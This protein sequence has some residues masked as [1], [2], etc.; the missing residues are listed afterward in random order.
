MRF[1]VL[2]E[3]G[4]KISSL[5]DLRTGHEWMWQN[6]NLPHRIPEYGRNFE[7][8]LDT[9]GWDELFPSVAACEVDGVAVPD[10]GDLVSLPWEV[11]GHGE[12]VLS[13]R[14]GARSMPATMEREIRLMDGMPEFVLAYTLRNESDHALP[15]LV[16]T[17][18]LFAL[19]CG[20]CLDLPD[21]AVLNVAGSLGQVTVGDTI[22]GDVLNAMLAEESGSWAMK[23]FSAPGTVSRVGFRQPNGAGMRMSWDV[24]LLPVLGMWV[25]YGGWTGTGGTAY[26]NIGLEPGNASCDALS[27]ALAEGTAGSLAAGEVRRWEIRVE[28][29]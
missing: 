14:S 17:H 15:Y 24:A 7:R 22:Q 8:E 29:M 6:P 20:S 11:T 13:M 19:E 12:T 1:E 26:R 28:L 23:I 25:N 21:R 4:G 9:G 5:V 27:D 18:P 10:H 16:A 3:C 2:P